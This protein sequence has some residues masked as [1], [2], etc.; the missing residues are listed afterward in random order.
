MVKYYFSYFQPENSKPPLI[1]GNDLI[2]VFALTPSPLFKIILRRVEEARIS[3][4]IKNKDEA[5][6]LVKDIL[7]T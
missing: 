4:K 1:T 5:M 2:N 3:K 7:E 6:Q